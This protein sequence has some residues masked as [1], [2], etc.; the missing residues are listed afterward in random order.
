M[1]HFTMQVI[2]T[3]LKK[4]NSVPHQLCTIVCL[5]CIRYYAKHQ[6]GASQTWSLWF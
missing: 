1:P 5:L 6:W 3:A 4:I 2:K